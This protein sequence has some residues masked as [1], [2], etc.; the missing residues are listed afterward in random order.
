LLSDD[1]A[2]RVR[3]KRPKI[4]DQ[5]AG[6][7]CQQSTSLSITFALGFGLGPLITREQIQQHLPVTC[8]QSG[9][10]NIYSSSSRP[11]TASSLSAPR[12]I[13]IC[14]L[15]KPLPACIL[16]VK[17]CTFDIFSLLYLSPCRMHT[18]HTGAQAT[19]WT[20]QSSGP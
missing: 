20:K 5:S 17:T 7:G 1:E 16:L 8:Q 6:G 4:K 13:G 2:H 14:S 18:S 12:R 19:S 15:A 10:Y 11:Y 3:Q 9:S